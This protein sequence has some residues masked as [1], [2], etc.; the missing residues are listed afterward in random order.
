MELQAALLGVRLL[1][2]VINEMRAPVKNTTFWSDSKTVLAWIN[3]SQRIYKQ[4]IANRIGEILD[5]NTTNQWRW[6]P[7]N[8]NPA[9]EA[10]KNISGP[11]KWVTGP[12]FLLLKENERPQN[13]L[14]ETKEEEV[15]YLNV[16]EAK[17][18]YIQEHKFSNW[19][20]L[21][22]RISTIMKIVDFGLNK[23]L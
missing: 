6:I 10:I 16:H 13:I 1:E 9:D 12:P 20:K 5:T 4:L 7:S 8:S 22:F 17:T 21:M 15:H 18:D 14:S 11:S 19:W 3:S 23:K 2:S